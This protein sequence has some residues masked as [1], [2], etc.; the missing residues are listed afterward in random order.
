MDLVNMVTAKQAEKAK[1]SAELELRL[2]F[3]S[4]SGSETFEDSLL[5]F[6]YVDS[7]KQLIDLEPG[8]TV[9]VFN[10]D[11]LEIAECLVKFNKLFKLEPVVM[12]GIPGQVENAKFAEAV[13]GAPT[14]S[15]HRVV[16]DLVEAERRASLMTE[17]ERAE[18]I[19][20]A[21]RS[22]YTRKDGSIKP[23]INFDH[24]LPEEE[25]VEE[26][27]QSER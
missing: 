7:V 16:G 8:P 21:E 24:S 2:V 10:D 3:L 14:A 18:S 11:N 6:A 19:N 22:R 4:Q 1:E 27:A 12:E 26:D 5:R 9:L 23:L 17:Q 20:A 25:V 15:Y 13:F